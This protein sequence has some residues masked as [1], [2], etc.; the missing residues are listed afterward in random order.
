MTIRLAIQQR[1]IPSY[2][3]PFLELLANQPTIELGVFAGAPQ[4][5]EQINFVKHIQNVDFEFSKNKHIF[6][7]KFYFCLQPA[8]KTWI[9]N[10]NPDI[11]IAEANPRYLSTPAVLKWMRSKSKPVLGW[12]LG[13]PH[14]SGMFSGLR[15]NSRRKFLSAFSGMIAY[16]QQGAKQ[17]LQSGFTPEQVY[18]AKNA[19]SPAPQT[20]PPQR[21]YFSIARK[22]IVLYV[23]RLQKRKRID[24]LINVCGKLPENIQPELW[25]VGNGEIRDELEGLAKSVYPNTRFWGQK[26]GEELESIF[27][28]ADLFVLPGTG[29]LAV[30]QAM[31]FALP[32]VVAEGDGT[33]SDLVNETNGWNILPN[34][35]NQLHEVILEALTSPEKMHEKGLAGYEKVKNSVNIENM[36][37][38]FMKAITETLVRK[39]HQ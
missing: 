31:S 29:G 5:V 13:V 34:D 30:Q 12:G 28:K 22:P 2:R 37:S 17:Y 8:F 21:S 4:D 20:D 7:G 10:W 25:I 24:S 14:Y 19:T 27:I 9:R 6:E 18:I 39:N 15:N 16:S 3:V 38:V 26:F 32:V 35:E 33:Q 1:V 36:V 23:G 11:L